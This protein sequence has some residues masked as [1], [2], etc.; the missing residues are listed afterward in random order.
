MTYNVFGRTLN[1]ALAVSLHRS[2]IAAYIVCIAIST[3]QWWRSQHVR[4]AL[5]L[6]AGDDDGDCHDA[7]T[8]LRSTTS[9]GTCLQHCDDVE[10]AVLCIAWR[11][12]D[13]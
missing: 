6:A 8:D 5:G 7:E 12:H 13:I 11:A 4:S 1:L 9:S 2:G 10:R 3:Q